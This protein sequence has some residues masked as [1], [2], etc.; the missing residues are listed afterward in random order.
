MIMI[1][2]GTLISERY[3][4]VNRIGSGGMAEV[5]DALDIVSKEHVAL[6]II[7]E[8]LITDKTVVKRF[9]TEARVAA[10]LNHPNIIKVHNVGTSGGRPY[11]VNELVK[12][13]TVRSILD[14]RG[15]LSLKEACDIMLQLTSAV[16]HAHQKKVIHCD[17]KTNN[18]FLMP[19]GSVKLADFGLARFEETEKK[20]TND[21]EEIAGSVH[22][23][24]PEV[25]QGYQTT[26]LS[27][28]YSL[29]IV[30]F[31]LLTGQLPY[32]EGTKTTIAA[33][34]VNKAFPR[35]TKFL[36]K[37][38]I[39]VEKLIEKATQ[40]KPQL[41]FV[42]V[43]EMNIAVNNIINNDEVMKGKKT[44]LQ[45]VFGFKGED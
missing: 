25:L 7:H 17:I 32:D 8:E 31:E 1:K 16:S 42:S 6:K 29:G 35:I 18:F 5:Y 9:E 13:Q 30:F 36:P 11:I 19:D 28:V 10:S 26:Y 27:D 44:L 38:P 39:E 45:R 14:Y 24:A 37:I 21:V 33:S 4:I 22:Y 34:H 43:E 40:K 3:R 15:N 2:T 12:G 41:R 23:L 20:K